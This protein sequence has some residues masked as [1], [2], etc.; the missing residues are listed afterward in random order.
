M[1]PALAVDR[2]CSSGGKQSRSA[3]LRGTGASIIH[4]FADALIVQTFLRL[5]KVRFAVKDCVWS[6]NSP[7]GQVP[8]LETSDG[9]L[10]GPY[11]SDSVM[12]EFE[13][14]KAVIAHYQ[15]PGS[16]HNLD[17][18]L[19][20]SQAADL[21][22]FTALVETKLVPGLLYST[23]CEAAWIKGTREAHGSE[24]PF[25][26]SYYL[27]YTMRRIVQQA[28]GGRDAGDTYREACQVLDAVSVRLM[29]APE[30][31]PFFFG[32]APSSLDALLFAC[33]AYIR[34]CPSVHP[35]LQK[36]MKALGALGRYIDRIAVECYEREVAT[37]T[38]AADLKWS[39]W[40]PG[41]AGEKSREGSASR[42]SE[43]EEEMLRRGR[44]W[45]M[46]TG[47]AIV[48]YV[49]LSGQYIEVIQN[50]GELGEDDDGEDDY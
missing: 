45:L 34:S 5:A 24:L 13:S 38:A 1:E 6:S 16:P 23:W 49:L 12:S 42:K 47:V 37:A 25:P 33:L 46:A 8:A 29:V 28:L 41:A 18:H 3:L 40:K 43:R 35:E 32:S 2:M 14:A 48:G 22:A 4:A 10:V 30:A 39:A 17:S 44:L 27:P 20:L 9:E 21:L 50:L 19:S 26:L 15:K 36:A 7:T 11:I 31:G